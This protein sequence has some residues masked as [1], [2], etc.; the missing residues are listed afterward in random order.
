MN[1]ILAVAM[2]QWFV[3]S[4]VITIVTILLLNLIRV[5]RTANITKQTIVDI[6]QAQSKKDPYPRDPE[7]IYIIWC[8]GDILTLKPDWSEARCRAALESI[9]KSMLDSSVEFGWSTMDAALDDA[10]LYGDLDGI[11]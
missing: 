5:I 7:K 3:L 6:K 11:K 8:W 1:N 9:R 10:I 2:V 4:C